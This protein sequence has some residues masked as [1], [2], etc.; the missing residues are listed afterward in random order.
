MIN[1]LLYVISL[2]LSAFAA[3]AQAMDVNL[4]YIEQ[5]KQ[6][7]LEEMR[8]ARVPASIKLGQ[9]ILESGGGQS[10]L[11]MNARNHFGVKCGSSWRGPTYFKMD[12][13]PQESCFRAYDRVEDSYR[14]H[15]DNFHAKKQIYGALF[16]LDLTDYRGWAYELKR[17]GY[18]TAPDYAEKLI[19]VIERY[20]L[21]RYDTVEGVLAGAQVPQSPQPHGEVPIPGKGKGTAAEEVVFYVNDVRVTRAVAGETPKQVAK[22]TFVS[23]GALL[24]YND[25]KWRDNEPLSEGSLVYI[26][27]KRNQWRGKEVWHT[28]K[29]GE[30]LFSIAQLYG[31]KLKALYKRNRLEVGREPRQLARVKI[32]GSQVPAGIDLGTVPGRPAG[33]SGEYID[34]PDM[35]PATPPKPETPTPAEGIKPTAPV[36]SPTVPEPSSTA[37]YHTVVAGD[38]LFS[39]SR[40]YGTSVADLK[41]LNQLSSDTISTGMQLRVQ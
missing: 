11:A 12:D 16:E 41:R 14:D 28:V 18:A 33:Q 25:I 2:L 4:V 7:A 34:F 21:W 6:L 31:V 5:Y 30:T 35:T 26:Q 20:Q 37:V 24:R 10:E 8:R 39:L 19:G 27:A 29:P 15:S 3:G 1:R 17:A 13:E 36:L 22:R 38:T 32:K 40:R 23:T 9:G